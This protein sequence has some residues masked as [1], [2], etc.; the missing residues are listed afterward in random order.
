MCSMSWCR[1]CVRLNESH[2]EQAV[3][4]GEVTQENFTIAI[5]ATH[6]FLLTFNPAV[7]VDEEVNDVLHLHQLIRRGFHPAF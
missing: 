2:P 3:R 4:C 1:D 7:I 6:D 5:S